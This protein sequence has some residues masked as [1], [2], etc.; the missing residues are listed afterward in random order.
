MERWQ[1]RNNDKCDHGRVFRYAYDVIIPTSQVLTQQ[2][3][4]WQV[5]KQAYIRTQN[6]HSTIDPL[7]SLWN[8]KKQRASL[9]IV[10]F[11]VLSVIIGN[12]FYFFMLL[13]HLSK[14]IIASLARSCTIAR[15]HTFRIEI[16]IISAFALFSSR[17][18][19][20]QTFNP[21][22]LDTRTNTHEPKRHSL[23]FCFLLCKQLRWLMRNESSKQSKINKWNLNRRIK[24]FRCRNNFRSANK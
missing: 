19:F 2:S 16:W 13:S 12:E 5:Y 17:G 18:K 14:N 22:Q 3:E 10:T 21:W 11:S 6:T 7:A 1:C 8:V 23:E 20:E 24:R 9:S 4:W 15:A